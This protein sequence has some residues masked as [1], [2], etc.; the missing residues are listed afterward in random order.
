MR[1]TL[2]NGVPVPQ[3]EETM[4]QEFYRKTYPPEDTTAKFVNQ[5]LCEHFA[6]RTCVN[7]NNKKDVPY[8]GY[9]HS[10]CEFLIVF[11]T[12]ISG[13]SNLAVQHLSQRVKDEKANRTD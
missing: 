11:F 7:C 8:Y 10:G 6:S 3:F 5:K 1:T 9:T 2:I 12:I 4:M 13:Q